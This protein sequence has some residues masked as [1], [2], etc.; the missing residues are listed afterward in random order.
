MLIIR[1]EQMAIFE[2]AAEEDFERRLMIAMRAH[3][4]LAVR[5]RSD[6]ELRAEVRVAIARARGHGF[7]HESTIADFVSLYFSVG[8]RFDE[9]P[10]V[11]AILRDEVVPLEKRVRWLMLRLSKEEWSEARGAGGGG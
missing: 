9:Y 4:P 8:A 3:H 2:R 11:R 6:E 1:R 10:P 5:D 7:R